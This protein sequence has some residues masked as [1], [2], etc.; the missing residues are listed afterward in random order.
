MKIDR[1][2][3]NILRE[4]SRNGR[5]SN[6][7]QA[8]G[9]SITLGLFAA[10]S[11]NGAGRCHSRSQGRHYVTVGLSSYTKAAQESFERAMV[12]AP[13]VVECLNVAGAF[14]Y[15]LGVECANLTDYKR[16]HPDALGMRSH[17]NAIASYSI[18]GSPKDNRAM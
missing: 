1:Q 2:D 12:I 6:V 8:E 10:R 18:M 4:L 7:Q 9:K 16:F 14:K 3:E 13:E 5:I 15:L 17:V 11:V